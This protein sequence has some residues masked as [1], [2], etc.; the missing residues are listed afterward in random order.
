M[1]SSQIKIDSYL[2]QFDI[3]N[4]VSNIIEKSEK[5]LGITLGEESFEEQKVRELY[6]IAIEIRDLLVFDYVWEHKHWV[7]FLIEITM[8]FRL[9][10][11]T[12]SLFTFLSSLGL[13]G[14]LDFIVI[15]GFNNSSYTYHLH[16][17]YPQD[18][19]GLIDRSV[20]PENYMSNAELFDFM[21]HDT[22]LE[23]YYSL[24]L[25]NVSTEYINLF[26]RKLKDLLYRLIWMRTSR[27]IIKIDIQTL[28]IK[29]KS[30]MVI[31]SSLLGVHHKALSNVDLGV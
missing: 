25:V 20:I 1:L 26:A 4:K 7:K 22:K 28:N 13:E 15:D 6:P 27:T 19:E 2:K 14:S 21:L 3:F 17:S 12:L 9:K 10:G 23:S 8:A 18:G 30:E 11:R 16:D 24:S 5:E 29:N 31:H